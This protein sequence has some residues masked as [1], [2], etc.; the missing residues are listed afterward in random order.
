MKFNL[1]LFLF[2]FF[3]I[4]NIGVSF[5]AKKNHKKHEQ[6]VS[7]KQSQLDLAVISLNQLSHQNNL[8]KYQSEIIMEAFTLNFGLAH[9]PLL[10][11]E[12][13]NSPATSQMFVLYLKAH[14]CSPCNMPVI[15]R[16]IEQGWQHDGFH[17]VSHAS[18]RHFL[19]QAINDDDLNNPQKLT[20]MI[21]PL[22]ANETNQYDAE[23]L[24]VASTG[25][26]TGLLP[27]ELMKE[28]ALFAGL[29]G[30]KKIGSD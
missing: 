15:R 5:K 10:L 4:V 28:E 13:I 24:L 14:A 21:G 25:L 7:E 22:Y 9:E 2:V 20:W 12:V 19:M 27:L 11:P 23:L 3:V 17:I 8:L 6:I 29:P 1:S 16:L 30:L 18:N 26:I